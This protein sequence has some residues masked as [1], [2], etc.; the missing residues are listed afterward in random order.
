MTSTPTEVRNPGGGPSLPHFHQ[1]EA[2]VEI[3]AN[4]IMWVLG[5]FA[6]AGYVMYAL[7][8]R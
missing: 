7:L 6:L 2:T 1:R 3:V 4:I 5:G 8:V